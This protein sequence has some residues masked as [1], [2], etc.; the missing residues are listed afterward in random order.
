MPHLIS[1]RYPLLLGSGSPRR[2]DILVGLGIPITVRPAAVDETQHAGEPVSAYLAR[3]VDSKL[4][5]A[6][7]AMLENLAAAALVAD[8]V[9]VVDGAVLGKPRDQSDALRLLKLLAGREHRVLTRFSLMRPDD[10]PNAFSAV[11]VESRVR[12]RAAADDELDRYARTGE[13]FDKAG[14]YAVQGCGAF[15]VERIEGSHSN[16]IGLPACELVLELKR[17][18]LLDGFPLVAPG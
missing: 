2:R 13:G 7:P 14:A 16:V 4:Q 11:T 12:M 10:R 8:T 18:E 1:K 6:V 15:L 17:A 9:V 5:A 3:V